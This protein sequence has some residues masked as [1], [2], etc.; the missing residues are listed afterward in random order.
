MPENN[1]DLILL[2]IEKERLHQGEICT[3]NLE[4]EE[5]FFRKT[6]ELKKKKIQGRERTC[7]MN[8]EAIFLG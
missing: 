7:R 5:D 1:R 4:D 2:G 8:L 6:R 3:G